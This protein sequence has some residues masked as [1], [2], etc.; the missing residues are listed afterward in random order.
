MVK[1]VQ[2]ISCQIS[3]ADCASGGNSSDWNK[4]ENTP[5]IPVLSLSGRLHFENSFCASILHLVVSHHWS[6]RTLLF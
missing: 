4:K 1:I 2:I 6:L 3:C 5:W